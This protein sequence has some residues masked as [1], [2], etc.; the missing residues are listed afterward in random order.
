VVVP[1]AGADDRSQLL[2]AA[3]PIAQELHADHVE[4][5]R[6]TAGASQQVAQILLDDATA[7]PAELERLLRTGHR[8]LLRVPMT[9]GDSQVGA[10]NATAATSVCGAGT[11]SVTRA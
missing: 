8:S 7:D 3:E 4:F 6:N 1:L 5:V 9:S 11:R 10:L 2:E